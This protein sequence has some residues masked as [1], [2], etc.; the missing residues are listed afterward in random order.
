MPIYL[1]QTL[2][3]EYRRVKQAFVNSLTQTL[4]SEKNELKNRPDHQ[5]DRAVE[6]LSTSLSL[7]KVQEQ[8]N[9]QPREANYSTPTCGKSIRTRDPDATNQP[10]KQ[11]TNRQ[12]NWNM[13]FTKGGKNPPTLRGQAAEPIENSQAN[14]EGK[15]D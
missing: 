5:E 14:Q 7:N 4:Q 12:L 6:R 8:K 2:Q 15:L 1:T 9:S 3:T 13:G 11:E 10:E